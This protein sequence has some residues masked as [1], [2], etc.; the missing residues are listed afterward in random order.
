MDL[1]LNAEVRCTDGVAGHSTCIILN[2]TTSEITHFVVQTKGLLGIEFLVPVAEIRESAPHTIQLRCT[3]HQLFLMEPF[4]RAEYSNFYSL[5]SVYGPGEFMPW[6]YM[7]SA[8]E[9]DTL[10]FDDEQMP[11][12]EL[13]IHRGARVEAIDGRVGR[14]DEFLIN[15]ANNQ[16]THLVLREGHLWGQKDITIPVA[17]IARIEEDVVYLKLDKQRVKSLPAIPVHG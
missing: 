11:L 13:G 3:L 8:D 6:P 10:P 1:P 5:P 16:I 12:N 15:Q 17:A 14:V 7:M 2:P 4:L 9:P